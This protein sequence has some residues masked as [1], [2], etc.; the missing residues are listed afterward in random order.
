MMDQYNG[1]WA[2]KCLDVYV[3]FEPRITFKDKKK[4]FMS[5]KEQVLDY[6]VFIHYWRRFIL[7]WQN[8]HV[9]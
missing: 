6:N 5:E 4:I 1:S 7:K 2:L 3:N 8:E 9:D